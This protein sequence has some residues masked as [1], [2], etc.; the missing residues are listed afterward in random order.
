MNATALEF[1]TVDE[2]TALMC[3][4]FATHLKA[5]NRHAE[6][7]RWERISVEAGRPVDPLWQTEAQQALDRL[8][9]LG[10]RYGAAATAPAG[11]YAAAHLLPPVQISSNPPPIAL[12]VQAEALALAA[13]RLREVPH[14][15]HW[16]R[17]VTRRETVPPIGMPPTIWRARRARHRAWLRRLIVFGRAQWMLTLDAAIQIQLSCEL[18]RT[19]DAGEHARQLSMELVA[20]LNQIGRTVQWATARLDR[21]EAKTL[22]RRRRPRPRQ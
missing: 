5:Q 14:T 2:R 10:A 17:R 3:G 8:L 4:L 21:F 6:A 12:P 9:R 1:L 18:Q 16:I 20:A 19:G 7:V 15:V 22:H 13:E 11:G